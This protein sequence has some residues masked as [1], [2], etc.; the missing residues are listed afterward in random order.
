MR[1]TNKA[2]SF[3]EFALLLPILLLIFLG[4]IELVFFVARYNDAIYLARQAS[5]FASV[6]DPFAASAS[7]DLN[8]STTGDFNF[9]YDT[10][11]IFSP[12]PTS[13]TCSDPNFCNG[14]SGYYDLNMTTDDI[15]ITVFSA[16]NHLVISQFPTDGPWVLSNNDTDT[17]HN[18]NWQN[19]CHGGTDP[20]KSPFFTDDTVNS[21]LRGDSVPENGFV[22]V[23]AYICYPQVLGM[24]ILSDIIPNPI[25]IHVYS[26]MPLPAARPTPAPSP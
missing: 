24:P 8:C 19:D 11:C 23:E 1:V 25:P 18:N 26:I 10:A 14:F 7:G 22:A 3:V 12:V 13:T 4:F 21:Y 6:R 17:A 15:L 20:A 5:R 2:Q 16:A 9:F